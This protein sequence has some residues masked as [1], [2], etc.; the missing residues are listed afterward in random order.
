MKDVEQET[1]F[2]IGPM[3]K[4]RINESKRASLDALLQAIASN[5]GDAPKITVWPYRIGTSQWIAI[6]IENGATAFSITI[7]VGGPLDLPSAEYIQRGSDLSVDVPDLVDAF[8][9][10]TSLLQ[11]V[12]AEDILLFSRTFDDGNNARCR[13]LSRLSL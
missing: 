3:G 5:V 9:L 10:W 13:K 1:I 4:L 6:D 12:R 8:Y 11:I 7:S 2:D